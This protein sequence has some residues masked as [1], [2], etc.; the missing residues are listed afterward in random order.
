MAA[1]A[2]DATALAAK[3]L[4]AT[5][6]LHDPQSAP[7][8]RQAATE[9][10]MQVPEHPAAAMAAMQLAGPQS[11]PTARFF[12]FRV[13]VGIASKGKLR[14]QDPAAS[15]LCEAL[16]GMLRDSTLAANGDL[17]SVPAFVR[18]KYA[19]AFAAAVVYGTEWPKSLPGLQQLLLEAGQRS[20]LHAALALTFFRAVAEILQ[21]DAATHL[22]PQRRKG[23]SAHFVEISPNIFGAVSQWVSSLYPNN[24]ELDRAVVHLA[25]EL[26]AIMPVA[27]FL[28]FDLDKFLRS[29]LADSALRAD[30]LQT[31]TDWVTKDIA[32]DL[33]EAPER[34]KQFLASIFELVDFCRTEGLTAEVYDAHKGVAMLIRDFVEANKPSLEKHPE[35]QARAYQAAVQLLRYPS[36]FIQHEATIMLLFVMK[37]ALPPPKGGGKPGG[38]PAAQPSAPPIPPWLRLEAELLPLLFL[39]LHKQLP[40]QFELFPL[41][42]GFQ[43]MLVVTSELDMEEDLVEV[44]VGTKGRCISI[45]YALAPC[46]AALVQCLAFSHGLLP[47][48]LGAPQNSNLAASFDAALL[49]PERVLQNM[50]PAFGPQG[51]E[52]CRTLLQQVFNFSGLSAEQEVRRLEFLSKASPALET[53]AE[54]MPDPCRELVVG[55]FTHL[56]RFIEQGSQ[57]LKTRAMKTFIGISRAAPK[58]IR[59]VLEEI[60]MKAQGLLPSIEHGQYLLCESVV[61]ASTAAGNFEQQC[62]LLRNLLSPILAKWN[63]VTDRLMSPEHSANCLLGNHADMEAA[64]QMVLCF[65][66]CFRSSVVPADPAAAAAGG[67]T[68]AGAAELRVRNPVG[69]IVRAV[70]PRLTAVTRSFHCTFPSDMTR[71]L[72]GIAG[73]TASTLAPYLLALDAEELKC[74]TSS[75]DMKKGEQDF[76]VK[77]SQAFPIPPGQDPE[78]V[79]RGRHLLYLVRESLYHSIGTALGVQDGTLTNAEL[80]ALL[81]SSLIECLEFSHPYH[82]ELQLRNV[83]VPLFGSTGMQAASDSLRRSLTEALLPKLLS[84]LTRTLDRYWQWLQLPEGHPAAANGNEAL[85]FAM[86]TGTVMASRTF[87]E[88]VAQMVA[89]GSAATPAATSKGSAEGQHEAMMADC[90][91]GKKKGKNRQAKAADGAEPGMADGGGAGAAGFGSIIAVSLPLLEAVQSAINSAI[92]WPDAKSLAHALLALQVAGLRV[93]SGG[94]AH[95]ALREAHF[96][97]PQAT[98]RCTAVVGLVLKPLVALCLSPPAPPPGG[99]ALHTVVGHPLADFFS[100]EKTQGRVAP[101]PFASSVASA[102]WPSLHGMCQVFVSMHKPGGGQLVEVQHIPKFPPMAE[103]CALLAQLNRI[104]EQDVQLLMTTLLDP[105]ADVKTKRGALRNLIRTA[106]DPEPALGETLI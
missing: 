25:Q 67:F 88:L 46:P 33:F 15:Q 43:Q 44:Q 95:N 28:R 22:Q 89:Q 68:V 1:G 99:G 85:L 102:M 66:G 71:P 91:G 36:H 98:Q 40:P 101:S 2:D 10:V 97:S 32:K 58:A 19:Q 38:T 53:V 49:L 42:A 5:Q 72:V 37:A 100:P 29:K 55:V 47:R 7:Q 60:V 31:F 57:E 82:V 20:P 69:D 45:L 62:N 34:M 4:E 51:A 11:P 26:A 56:F 18:E 73:P 30:V 80:P 103:A 93:M 92:R 52:A 64:R 24:P 61:A 104:R 65:E 8:V 48:V 17:A 16:L 35:L 14:P 74:L 27:K 13:L 12:A 76:A 94:E 21:S 50:K 54:C 79:Q 3:I 75:H 96:T 87:V 63:D 90:G 59:P 106:V 78:R 86:C 83:W 6:A 84:A 105:K 23:L 81:G 9:F 39:C 41:P 70:F 77:F